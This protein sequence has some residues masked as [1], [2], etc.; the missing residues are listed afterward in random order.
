MVALAKDCG[1][2]FDTKYLKSMTP[3]SAAQTLGKPYRK[4]YRLLGPARRKIGSTNP[5]DEAVHQSAIQR[6]KTDPAYAP[7]NLARFLA[8]PAGK[9][10]QGVV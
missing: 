2:A 10:D 3:A 1:L 5:R 9:R 6:F 4:F 8:T 7:D